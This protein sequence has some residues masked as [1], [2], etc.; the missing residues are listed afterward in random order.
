MAKKYYQMATITETAS[1]LKDDGY[2]IAVCALRRFIKE[3]NIPAVY[4][5]KKAMV[6]YPNVISF[7]TSGAYN[8]EPTDVIEQTSEQRAAEKAALLTAALKTVLQDIL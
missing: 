3:G 6:Y 2:D 5:G 8:P 1:H 7:L 4:S